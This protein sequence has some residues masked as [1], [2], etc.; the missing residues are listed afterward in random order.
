MLVLRSDPNRVTVLI[1]DANRL[2]STADAVPLVL[3][4]TVFALKRQ[5]LPVERDLRIVDICRREDD[6]VVNDVA[7]LLP[8]AF[9][10]TAVNGPALADIA[11]SA[12]FPSFAVIKA[13]R[14]IFGH[15]RLLMAEQ[16]GL[17]PTHGNP[18][19]N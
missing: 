5:V 15:V 14:P 1:E 2:G 10:Q 11:V 8:A 9:A 3:V 16:A 19:V 12:P 13:L 7:D 17:E 6:L 4:V 18:P